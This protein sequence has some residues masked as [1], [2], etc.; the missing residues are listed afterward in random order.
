MAAPPARAAAAPSAD[1]PALRR[2]LR[3]SVSV[4]TCDCGAASTTCE[5]RYQRACMVHTV[6]YVRAERT[7]RPRGGR[8]R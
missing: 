6:Q 5:L 7:H 2:V 3:G 1:P 4:P 8:C